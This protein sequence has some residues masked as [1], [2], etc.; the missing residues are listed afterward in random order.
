MTLVMLDVPAHLVPMYVLAEIK[1][2]PELSCLFQQGNAGSDGSSGF[3]GRRVRKN[4]VY[5]YR[6][7]YTELCLL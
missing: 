4:C 6:T 1:L 3:P 5:E 7:V 2:A